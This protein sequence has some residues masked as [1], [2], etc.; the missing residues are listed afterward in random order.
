MADETPPFQF[1]GDLD[2]QGAVE[3][4]LHAARDADDAT[5]SAINVVL[6][7]RVRQ[8]A[9][10]GSTPTY[11]SAPSEDGTVLLGPNVTSKDDR[12]SVNGVPYVPQSL[13]D[14]ALHEQVLN[15]AARLQVEHAGGIGSRIRQWYGV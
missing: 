1:D 15:I 7:Q 5:L 2:L 4:A 11:P 14:Q 3:Q 8:E 10:R 9:L 12:I 13:Q 6:Y